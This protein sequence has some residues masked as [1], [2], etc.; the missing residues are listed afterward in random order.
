MPRLN[1]AWTVS[2]KHHAAMQA[3]F[4]AWYNFGRKHETLKGKTPTMAI[5]LTDH[6]WKL[7]E[8]LA[9]AAKHAI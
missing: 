1:R 8:S 7:E 2:A 4:F 6:L 5:G 3:I 9:E